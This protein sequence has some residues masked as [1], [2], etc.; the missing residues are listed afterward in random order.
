MEGVFGPY[1]SGRGSLTENTT[2]G[3][4]VPRPHPW[5]C[6]NIGG[7]R[8]APRTHSWARRAQRNPADVASGHPAVVAPFLFGPG[9]GNRG[10]PRRRGQPQTR[11]LIG[12]KAT[13]A[14]QAGHRWPIQFSGEE[15]VPVAL[16]TRPEPQHGEVLLPCR[17]YIVLAT[18]TS[19]YYHPVTR[20]FLHHEFSQPAPERFL[21]Y[22]PQGY[23]MQ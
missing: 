22:T 10:F 19:G 8:G 21:N 23:A 7:L 4:G 9:S 14:L 17:G 12:P 11:L 16:W 2:S 20:R 5:P 18:I 6:T 15:Q 13:S 3:R 1:A